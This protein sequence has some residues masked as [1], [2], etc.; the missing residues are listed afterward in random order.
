MQS[1]TV[2]ESSSLILDVTSNQTSFLTS[3]LIFTKYIKMLLIFGSSI[4]DISQQEHHLIASGK[5]QKLNRFHLYMM[6]ISIG[7][8]TKQTNLYGAEYCN[9]NCFHEASLESSLYQNPSEMNSCTAIDLLSKVRG[10]KKAKHGEQLMGNLCGAE[11][12]LVLE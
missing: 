10:E 1:G 7:E 5:R 3:S 2:N 12:E 8:E 11:I 6:L 4:S 9:I